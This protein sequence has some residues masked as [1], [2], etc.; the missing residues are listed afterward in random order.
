M[1]KTVRTDVISTVDL[2]QYSMI[3]IWH[4]TIQYGKDRALHEAALREVNAKPEP[5]NLSHADTITLK[6][7]DD[8]FTQAQVDN[9]VKELEEWAVHP[10]SYWHPHN[11]T[12]C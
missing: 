4:M 5:E 8:T 11:K 12:K 3:F 9:L 7:L 6:D 2:S 1:K 10:N